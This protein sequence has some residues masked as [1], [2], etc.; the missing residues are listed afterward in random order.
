MITKRHLSPPP[1]QECN[2]QLEAIRRTN[3]D[4][5]RATLGQ[6]DELTSLRDGE[7]ETN[8]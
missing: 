1:P 8:G 5:A 7:K 2:R 3:A 4:V 6:K